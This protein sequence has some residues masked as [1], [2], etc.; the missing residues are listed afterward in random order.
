MYKAI[1]SGK[2]WLLMGLGEPS[3]EVGAEE[4]G[5]GGLVRDGVNRDSGRAR[6]GVIE[7]G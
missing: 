7:N 6:G 2:I 4:L 3:G 5:A 1:C